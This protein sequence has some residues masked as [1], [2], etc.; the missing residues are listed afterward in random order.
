MFI[1]LLGFSINGVKSW[2]L[3]AL[4]ITDCPSVCLDIAC[5]V[6]IGS[7]RVT[8]LFLSICGIQMSRRVWF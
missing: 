5:E 4:Y 3:H 8:R 7:C 1:G 2:S 6:T